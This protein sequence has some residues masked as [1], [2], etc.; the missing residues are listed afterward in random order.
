MTANDPLHEA[1]ERWPHLQ[2]LAD[3]LTVVEQTGCVVWS[4]R[5]DRDGYGSHRVEGRNVRLHRWSWEEANGRPIPDGLGVLHSC[6]TRACVNPD[7]LRPGSQRENMRDRQA[8][9]RQAKGSRNGR[10]KLTE[11]QVAAAKRLLLD[12][13]SPRARLA[14][15]LGVDPTTLRD[16][17][18]G[19]IWGHVDPE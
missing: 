4:G 2:S 18:R 13:V 6:H 15:L 3:R 5:T 7:H 19:R 12:G 10:S 1:F 17:E 11:R 16:V 9:D 8:A 14:R